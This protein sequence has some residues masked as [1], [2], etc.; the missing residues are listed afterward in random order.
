M[1][2]GENLFAYAIVLIYRVEGFVFIIYTKP[3]IDNNL[4]TM[5]YLVECPESN[6]DSISVIEYQFL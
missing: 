2:L 6:S 4:Y 5:I 1:V 3:K